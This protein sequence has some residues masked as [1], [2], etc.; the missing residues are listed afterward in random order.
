MAIRHKPGKPVEILNIRTRQWLSYRSLKDASIALGFD[1]K[2]VYNMMHRCEVKYQMIAVYG[3]YAYKFKHSPLD[4][5]Q[6][7]YRLGHTRPSIT[8]QNGCKTVEVK[9]LSNQHIQTFPSLKTAV[10]ALQ[11]DY[12]TVAFAMAH[13]KRYFDSPAVI[14]A[15]AFRYVKDHLSWD[16]TVFQQA[17]IPLLK[18]PVMSDFEKAIMY[19]ILRHQNNATALTIYEQFK[20]SWDCPMTLGM[21]YTV[22]KRLIKNQWIVSR[23]IKHTKGIISQYSVT[24]IGQQLLQAIMKNLQRMSQGVSFLSSE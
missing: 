23:S 19:A 12:N 6:S 21:I 2:I 22:L 16:H 20:Q 4:W 18:M 7:T 3:G 15:Y 10:L 11:M 9:R 8:S 13:S 1:Y 14:G 17:E 5:N 24:D